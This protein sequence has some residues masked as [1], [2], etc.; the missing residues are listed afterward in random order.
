M[1]ITKSLVFLAL[2][3]IN[4]NNTYAQANSEEVTPASIQANKVVTSKPASFDK[5]QIDFHQS[6]NITNQIPYF[7]NRFRIDAALDEITLVFFRVRGSKPIILVQPDGKKLRIKDHDR[8]TVA[9]H[10]DRTFDMIK[11]N[12]PMPGPWQVIGNVLPESKIFVVSDVKIVVEPLP[13][14]VLSG[15]TLKVVGQLYND[16]ENITIASFRD[17]VTL[18]VNFFSTN[19]SS[20]ENF[21]AD[22]IKVTSFR[23]DGYELDEYAGDSIYTGEFVLNFAS[24]EWQ[25]VFVIKM[26]MVTREL[27]QKPILLHKPPV[28]LSIEKSTRQEEPH[29][30]TLT[31]DPT[32]VDPN[33]LVFQGKITFPDKQ[34]KPFSIMEKEG[35]V[36]NE[37]AQ[38]R[39]KEIPYT[40]PGI[41]RV[42]I[43]A[44]GRTI[45]GREFRLVVPEFTFN[46]EALSN[47]DLQTTAD[48]NS[49]ETISALDAAEQALIAQKEA[50][51]KASAMQQKA[52]EEKNTQTL[53]I[54]VAG[55]GIII[56]L[57]L[58]LF[59]FIRKR[60]A[61]K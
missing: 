3:F 39:L 53:I 4:V 23:D 1:E 57:A 45:T 56:I 18:D 43:S 17:V 55:N 41:H 9:W 54:V 16:D 44:F 24:G 25:P 13:E 35:Q 46:V 15:E 30:L 36:A 51:A 2:V 47:A 42:N 52:A 22:A 34:N 29:Q 38:V 5:N 10:D 11:I 33:S 21:G 6:D 20:Y 37:N 40:E 58:I 14:I 61:K 60:N 32:N 59:M 48:D 50:L 19:N 26:P 8:K 27:R 31:I 7:D 28:T 49:A 12:K